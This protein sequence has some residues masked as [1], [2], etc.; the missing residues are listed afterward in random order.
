MV[1]SR[2]SG[3][4]LASSLKQNTFLTLGWRPAGGG[5]TPPT[6]GQSA[7]MWTVGGTTPS[8]GGWGGD[9]TCVCTDRGVRV[10]RR[11]G[12]GGQRL[13]LGTVP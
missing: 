3:V 1:V 10:F 12:D 13:K 5:V 6:D 9:R 8:S 11:G 4:D 7:A 2:A